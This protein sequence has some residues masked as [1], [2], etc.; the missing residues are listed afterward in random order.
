MFLLDPAA[1]GMLLL[2]MGIIVLL[3]MSSDPLRAIPLSRGRIWPL[4]D[5]DRRLLR[6]ISPWLNP[7][8]WGVVALAVWK[9]ASWGLAAL[10]GGVVAMGFITS[11]RSSGRSTFARWIPQFPSP[12]NHLIRKNLREMISTLDFWGG[13]LVAIASLGWRVAGLLPKEAFFPLT[14]VAMLMTSTCA[15]TLFG[16]DGDA[17][18]TRYRLL[19]LKGWQVLLAKD[20]AYLVIAILV[21]APLYVPG[22]LGGAFIGLA[23]GHRAS[24]L[25]GD[26]QLRW[27]FQTGPSFGDGITQVIAMLMSGAAVAYTSVF[28]LFPCVVCWMVS[29]WWFGRELDRVWS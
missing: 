25:T 15:L 28:L 22:A 21:A 13:A 9:R 16:L 2:L 8:T 7:M 18:L 12:L 20:I 3:P 10:G 23:V 29:V 5:K 6:L 1:A 24:V 27:R 19:P 17:G 4:E 14:A 11:S 26:P